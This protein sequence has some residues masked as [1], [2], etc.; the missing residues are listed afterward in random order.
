MIRHVVAWGMAG[1][2]AADRR[3]NA[4]AVRAALDAL[5]AAVPQILRLEVGVD[6]GETE[7]NGDVVLSVDVADRA[8][9]DAYQQ[10]PAHLEVARLIGAL[11][12]SR[13]CVDYEV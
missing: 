12:T 11:R 9:L 5:P 13:V 1:D 10:H 8:A 7:G 3:A 2:T 4:E 6:L